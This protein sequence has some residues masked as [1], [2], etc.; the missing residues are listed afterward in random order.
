MK[1]YKV[2]DREQELIQML[3]EV[4]ESS[5]KATYLFLSEEEIDHIR[6]YVP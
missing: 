2:E 4:W 1:I 6:R 3:L 5:V